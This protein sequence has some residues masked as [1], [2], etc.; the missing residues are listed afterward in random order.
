LI[1]SGQSA[2]ALSGDENKSPFPI[3]AAAGVGVAVLHQIVEPLFDFRDRQILMSVTEPREQL[4]TGPG[5]NSDCA[6]C[7]HDNETPPFV[8]W[9]VLVGG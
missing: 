6:I 4:F 3:R 8:D 9:P 7:G 2:G 1:R 5:L